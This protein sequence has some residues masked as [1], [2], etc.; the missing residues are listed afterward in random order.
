MSPGRT[1]RPGEKY[2]TE[3][4]LG[5]VKTAVHI[6]TV[7]LTGASQDVDLKNVWRVPIRAPPPPSR[8]IDPPLMGRH[9]GE[10]G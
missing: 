1:R 4:A 3:P 5:H 2:R 6:M 9:D 10:D 7:P 8:E